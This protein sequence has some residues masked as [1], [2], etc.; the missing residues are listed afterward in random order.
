MASGCAQLS[1]L[2]RP[3]LAPRRDGLRLLR[4]GDAGCGSVIAG[5][6]GVAGLAGL[7]VAARDLS[8]EAFRQLRL[9]SSSSVLLIGTE[10]ATDPD[11]YERLTKP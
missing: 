1:R 3:P 10:G 6:S 8:G 11:I 5:E 2:P 7:L 4:Q 9:D